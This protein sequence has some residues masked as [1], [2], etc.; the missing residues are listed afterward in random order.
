MKKKNGVLDVTIKNKKNKFGQANYL[1]KQTKKCGPHI[2]RITSFPTKLIP[3]FSN[4]LFLIF[5]WH[6][7]HH[8]RDPTR[9]KEKLPL[10]ASKGPCEAQSNYFQLQ[11]AKSAFAS[12]I[13]TI[14]LWI[15]RKAQA[16]PYLLWFKE[17]MFFNKDSRV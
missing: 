1:Y 16:Q 8:A 6:L 14:W 4:I 12:K 9:F 7:F 11:K 10:R 13:R 17:S 3:G 15:G 5:I 2:C